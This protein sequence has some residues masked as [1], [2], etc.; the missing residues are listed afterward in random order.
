[1]SFSDAG[2]RATLLGGRLFL[3]GR[4]VGQRET[5]LTGIA[6]LG[7]VTLVG[8]EQD[9]YL[10]TSEGEFIEAIELGSM[11]T[12]PVEQVGRAGDRV[13]LRSAGK[14]CQS[15]PDVAAFEVTDEVTAE[16]WSAG[17]PPDAEETAAL[18]AAWRGQGLTVER[19]LLDLHSGR[20]LSKTGP[21]LMDLVA[22]FLIV[23]SVSGLIMSNVRNR[24]K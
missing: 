9:V 18:E 8:G 7:P 17:T 14:L 24:R 4:D 2:H 22:V 1:M 12:G 15:D 20:I 19:V 11:L 21:V 6:A 3:D 5:T 23:L 16:Y 13:I 10:F